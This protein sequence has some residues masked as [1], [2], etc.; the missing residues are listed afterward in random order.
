MYTTDSSVCT[1]AR[2]AGLHASATGGDVRV[3]I[4]SG[5]RAYKGSKR[6]GVESGDWGRWDTA[7]EVSAVPAPDTSSCV[8]VSATKGWQTFRFER[9]V[10]RIASIKGGW[11]VDD[12]RYARVGAAGHTGKDAKRLAPHGKLKFDA[13]EPFGALL[14]AE[15]SSHRPATAPMSLAA[16]TTDVK[17]RINDADA[18]LGDNGGALTVCFEPAPASKAPAKAYPQEVRDEFMKACAGGGDEA[19]CRCVLHKLEQEVPL[20]VVFS[21]TDPGALVLPFVNACLAEA[22]AD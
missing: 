7:F 19:L 5:Q 15:G 1:A 12:A 6:N 22:E 14:I 3:T 21:T 13:G 8:S 20:D 11:S 9:P 2:H 18:A 10:S 17:L 16:A 4:V